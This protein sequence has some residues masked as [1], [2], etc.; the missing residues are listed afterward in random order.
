MI[1][2][3]LRAGSPVVTDTG[4]CPS[5]A[6]TSPTRPSG[7]QSESPTRIIPA[8]RVG[9]PAACGFSGPLTTAGD[10][11]CPGA[12]RATRTPARTEGP[13][14]PVADASSAPVLRDQ[15][16]D[17]PAGHGN[18]DPCRDLLHAMQFRLFQRA[19]SEARAPSKSRFVANATCP[20]SPMAHPHSG[21]RRSEGRGARPASRMNPGISRL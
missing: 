2:P 20:N 14:R 19:R 21:S 17:R 8:A 12:S 7:P 15:G 4:C 9:G 13:I 5:A 11:R 6:P 3:G 18:A 1:L 10:R 16:P